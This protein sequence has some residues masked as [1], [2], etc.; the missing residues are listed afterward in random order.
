MTKTSSPQPGNP[1]VSPYIMVKDV[2]KSTDFY[3]AAFHFQVRDLARDENNTITHAELLYKGQLLM[4]GQEGGWG[5]T[6]RCPTSSGVECPI[7]LYLYC[8]DVDAFYKHAVEAGAKSITA[9]ENMFWGDRM[10]S[11][12][13]PDGYVW[14]FASHLGVMQQ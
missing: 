14:C 2:K 7:S 9:P 13:D 1:W 4:F 3:Q 10:C 6:S 12:Q 5:S 8:E 11:L